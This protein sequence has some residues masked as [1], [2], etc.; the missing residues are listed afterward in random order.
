MEAYKVVVAARQWRGGATQII[1]VCLLLLAG[2]HCHP[3]I[4]S[5]HDSEQPRRLVRIVSSW[6]HIMGV[7]RSLL[8]LRNGSAGRSRMTGMGKHTG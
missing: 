7:G 8:T 4:Q 6:F 5:R 3:L 2:A 1:A